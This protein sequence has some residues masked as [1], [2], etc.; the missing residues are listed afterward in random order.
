MKNPRIPKHGWCCATLVLCLAS[1]FVAQA[2]PPAPHHVIH[3]MVRDEWGNPIRTPGARVLFETSDGGVRSAP[4]ADGVWPG[5]NYRLEIPLDAGVTSDL[6]S[7][8]ALRPTVGFRM[9]VV[10]GSQVYLPIEMVGRLE[11]LGEPAGITVLDLTL[12]EDTDGDGLPDAWERELARRLGL[13]FEDIHPDADP[14]GDGLSNREEYLAGTY[15][16]DPANGFLLTIETG[17]DALPLLR[18]LSV[19]GRTYAL[20]GSA[21]LDAEWQPVE[22]QSADAPAPAP[23]QVSYHGRD[24]RIVRVHPA[25][26]AME[27]KYFKLTV[28]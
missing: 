1:P 2:F 7:A 18:F 19:P 24:V 6:Y 11:S 12:G 20:T 13:S 4:L 25:P 5:R 9:R 16:Y 26:A 27:F 17:D 21:E 22:F 23:V 3:G 14:D 15:A 10:V 28:R 8:T